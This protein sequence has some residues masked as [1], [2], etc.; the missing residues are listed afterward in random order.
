MHLLKKLKANPLLASVYL[1][2]LLL[3]FHYYLIIYVN[4]SFL[5]QYFN[6]TQ[7]SAL[8]IFGS[9]LNLILLLNAS[10]LI[11]KFSNYTLITIFAILEF[12]AIGGMAVTGNPYLIAIFFTIHQIVISMILLHMDIFLEKASRSETE[13]GRIRSVYLTISNVVIIICTV[14][15]SLVLTD[16]NYSIVY[17]LSALFI[18]P[19]LFVIKRNFSKLRDSV[20]N[21][22]RVFS[23]VRS[24]LKD[25][26]I[27]KIFMSNLILQFFYAWM[28]IYIPIHLNTNLGIPWSQIALIFT[29]MLLPFVFIEIPAGKMADKKI[30]EKEMLTFGFIVAGLSVM[31]IPF[32]VTGSFIIWA[33][34]LFMTR[35]GASFIE[36]MTESYFFKQ[37]KAGDTDTIGLYRMTKPI[38]YIITPA[39][40]VL[41]LSFLSFANS[42]FVLG[43]ITLFGIRYSLTLKDTK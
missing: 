14:I 4:S 11:K 2:N 15:L 28:V 9:V 29:I 13:T 7:L 1:S 39:L 27:Y 21:D 34:L 18:I 6:R 38:A 24:F 20:P 25:R 42:F 5:D 31:F 32:I 16:G 40:V 22:L 36:I 17:L 41:S 35:V 12:V 30:G 19:M 3:A 37:V 10:R 33:V 43:L 26:N 23:A 8:Y